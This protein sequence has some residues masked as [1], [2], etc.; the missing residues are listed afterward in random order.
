MTSK[1][2]IVRAL[3]KARKLLR[4]NW[5]QHTATLGDG[6]GV[7]ML[8]AVAVAATG[9][10]LQ[11]YGLRDDEFASWLGFADHA[12]GL[13]WNDKKRRTEDQVLERFDVAIKKWS[14][15]HNPESQK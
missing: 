13:N 5:I 10:P 8:S 11:M 15:L 3:K 4:G 7:C 2:E 14:S 6:H 1:R 9:D 12:R